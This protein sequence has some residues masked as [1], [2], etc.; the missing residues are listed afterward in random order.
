MWGASPVSTKKQKKNKKKRGGPGHAC[1]LGQRK[2]GK[3]PRR[4]SLA[5]RRL[6]VPIVCRPLAVR[7]LAI[8][9][10]LAVRPLDV[11]HPLAVCPLS[12]FVVLSSPSFSS[13][14]PHRSRLLVPIILSLPF[15]IPMSPLLSSPRRP[16]MEHPVSS[17]SWWWGWVL[18]RLHHQ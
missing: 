18:G 9:H 16:P 12:P 2:E 14:R 3:N 1:P 7:P 4:L 10:P 13:S 11:C 5:F 6:L 8:C 15:I 17:C